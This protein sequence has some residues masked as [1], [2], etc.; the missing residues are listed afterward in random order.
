MLIH[1]WGRLRLTIIIFLLGSL[2]PYGEAEGSN[3]NRRELQDK[4]Q[5]LL[6]TCLEQMVMS[7]QLYCK[8][9]NEIGC[10]LRKDYAKYIVV[11]IFCKC[12]F[13]NLSLFHGGRPPGGCTRIRELI[14]ITSFFILYNSFM[15]LVALSHSKLRMEFS[16]IHNFPQVLFIK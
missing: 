8:F 1:S 10:H 16:E 4:D 5:S 9:A 11:Y 6:F 2:V 15:R 3:G 7:C 13:I 14:S 12:K